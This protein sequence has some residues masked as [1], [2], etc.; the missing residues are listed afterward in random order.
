VM[1]RELVLWID[2]NLWCKG[3]LC[4]EL[5]QTC[6]LQVLKSI[7]LL[8]WGL[9]YYV[10]NTSCL[11]CFLFSSILNCYERRWRW[12]ARAGCSPMRGWRSWSLQGTSNYRLSFLFSGKTF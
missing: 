7:D 4:C 3:K 12:T 9:S 1:Q 5:N 6:D 2:S 11:W 10:M 8:M